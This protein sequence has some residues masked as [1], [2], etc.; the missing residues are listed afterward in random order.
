[1]VPLNKP[2]LSR[3]NSETIAPSLM[4]ASNH[5]AQ[6]AQHVHI[7]KVSFAKRPTSEDLEAA[8]WLFA[9]RE[10][11][12]NHQ[13]DGSGVMYPE[14]D[15]AFHSSLHTV[16]PPCSNT[17]PKE[18]GSALR[19]YTALQHID[20][21]CR[22]LLDYFETELAHLISLAPMSCNNLL[23]V[24]MPMA[25]SH[26]AICNAIA[27][28]SATHSRDIDDNFTSESQRYLDEAV[29]WLVKANEDPYERNLETTLAV[30]LIICAVEVCKDADSE[31]EK[32]KGI[33][34]DIIRGRDLVNTF[35][36]RD[37]IFLL[38]HFAYHD[39]MSASPPPH[40]GSTMARL[41]SQIILTNIPNLDGPDVYMG[42]CSAL[43]CIISET[44]S[45][46]TKLHVEHWS[47]QTI[48]IHASR[49]VVE[50]DLCQPQAG[51]LAYIPIDERP[52]HL[53]MFQIL[54]YTAK[55][56]I[57]Q[58]LLRYPSNSAE[59]ILLLQSV[60]PLFSSLQTVLVEMLFLLFIVGVDSL[61]DDRRKVGRMLELMFD[62]YRF[63]NIR[64][65][66]TVLEKCWE[67]NVEG[68][69]FVDWNQ[70]SWNLF[71]QCITFA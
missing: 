46:A 39:V 54:Q 58:V 6:H 9:Y 24:F 29:S 33:A 13:L 23:R 44:T 43:Y 20:H 41:E 57:N 4:K 59:S 38:R 8:R 1:M 62:S 60:L 17:S 47:P 49:L 19:A 26:S 27:A 66:Y 16:S 11:D 34:H 28:W 12:A 55:M 14:Y 35:S 45:L 51:E 68:S 50:I 22:I 52:E 53:I 65:A 3:T 36:G 15:H 56:Y 37:Q 61:G 32:Y 64:C 2:V 42:I 10:K 40:I 63:G 70:V 67:L 18:Q 21:N 48:R 30:S 25:V 71:G 31:F 69:V 7:D 5:G